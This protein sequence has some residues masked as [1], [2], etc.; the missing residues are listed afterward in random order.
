MYATER[1]HPAQQPPK[2]TAVVVIRE[3]LGGTGRMGI[4]G[5]IERGQRARTSEDWLPISSRMQIHLRG[6]HP[7]QRTE[8]DPQNFLTARGLGVLLMRSLATSK[9]HQKKILLIYRRYIFVSYF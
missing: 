2:V 8:V 5:V 4:R 9:V 1:A 3:Q 6:S 7:P